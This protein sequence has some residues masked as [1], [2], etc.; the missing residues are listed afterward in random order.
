MNKAAEAIIVEYSVSQ[1]AFHLSTMMEM[2]TNNLNNIFHKKES[3]YLPIGVFSSSVEADTFIKTCREE[4]FNFKIEDQQDLA[5]SIVR[6]I[7]SEPKK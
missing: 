7:I 1:D 4:L 5:V 2:I 6:D 3:D